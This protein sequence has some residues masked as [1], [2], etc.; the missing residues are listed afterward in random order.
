VR[1]V[2]LHSSRIDALR[3]TLQEL[4][5][6]Q[7][8]YRIVENDDLEKLTQTQHHEGVCFDVVPPPVLSLDDALAV[9][10]SAPHAWFVWLDGVGN[11]HNLGAILRSAA[12]FGCAGVIVHR[13]ANLKVSGAAARVAEGGAEVVPLVR[14]G[15]TRGA[16]EKLRG[17]GF[18]LL[19]TSVREGDDLFD[20]EL[21]SKLVWLMGAE[22][23]GVSSSMQE[24]ADRQLQI[25]G[26]GKIESLNVAAAFAVFAAETCR[27]QR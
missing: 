12:H 7:I 4:A 18:E 15:D 11:P 17:A 25:P 14:I 2:Y 5:D 3:E 23:E 10:E 1:K 24:L 13:D 20:A 16:V 6:R 8:G 22:G 26:T 27:S 21:P 19:A 9:A